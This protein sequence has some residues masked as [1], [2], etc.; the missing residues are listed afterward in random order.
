MKPRLAQALGA[1]SLLAMLW[2]AGYLWDCRNDP[3]ANRAE[4]WTASGGLM[5]IGAA[6]QAGYWTPN[7][8]ITPRQRRQTAPADKPE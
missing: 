6:F 7:P 4:C 1:T 2:G 8:N 3:T 5:G